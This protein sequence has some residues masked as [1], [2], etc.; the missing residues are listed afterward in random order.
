MTFDEYIK[1]PM[2]DKN[3][4][5]SHREMYRTMYTEKFDKIMLREANKIDYKIYKEETKDKDVYDYY[6]HIKVPSEV[7]RKFYYDTVIKFVSNKQSSIGINISKYDVQF[8]SNDPSFV[9]TFAHAFMKNKLFIE[10][11]R[12]RMSKKAILEKPKE[13]NA[14]EQISYVK[15]LYFAYL[16]M[17]SKG[18]FNKILIDASS[19]KYN[20]LGL[21]AS[22]T[23]ADKKIEDRQIAGRELDD[24]KKKNKIKTNENIARESVKKEIE[25]TGK[26]KFI[27]GA[28]KTKPIGMIKTIKNTKKI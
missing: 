7:I 12:P 2:G 18:L 22:I 9:F 28:K 17:K 21:I 3:A 13:K 6:I 11:L 26:V 1:N 20:K 24:E 8:Y 25:S 16:I 23:P 14:K 27:S 4:V 19:T 15:S 5:I 10:D